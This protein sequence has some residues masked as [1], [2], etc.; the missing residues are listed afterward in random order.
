MVDAGDKNACATVEIHADRLVMAGGGT[1]ENRVLSSDN[2]P[3][4]AVRQ[5]GTSLPYTVVDTGQSLC[6]DTTQE[7]ACPRPGEQFY[8]QDA[9]YHGPQPAYRDNEDGT[10]SDLN[11]GLM[12][13]SSGAKKLTWQDAARGA[14]ACRVGGHDDW[15]L[16]TIKEMYSLILFSGTDP[17]LRGGIGGLK[18][19][20][21]T[22]F[23]PFQYGQAEDGDRL[24]DSQFATATRCVTPIMHGV[25]AMF[26][27]NFADGR[28]K[29]YPIEARG[30]RT[31][32]YHAFYVRGNPSYGRNDF[33]DNGD[34][35]VT[36]RATGL[37]WMKDDSGKGMT[38]EDALAYCENF[39]LAGFS[40]WRLPN[41]K[42]LQSI[43]DYT[44]SPDTS[45]SAALAPVFQATV[46]TNEGGNPDYPFYW[47]GTTHARLRGGMSAVYI[48]FGRALGFMEDRQRGGA[49]QLMD[50]HGAGAQRSDPK[51]GDP[52]RFPEGRG[53]QGDVVRVH[54][55]VRCVRTGSSIA[56]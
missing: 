47:T 42:E 52:R 8:G 15:R 40:D 1:V 4:A 23:F 6:Y 53:P 27:V 24:I 11:T 7:I 54:N 38:W 33:A 17:D 16:P 13:A 56:K 18:P 51:T 22:R 39:E 35:T 50:V 44:R 21:D 34:G 48:A 36:D 45:D 49:R 37:M 30:P 2:S 43:V 10:I 31:K 20:I 29:A 14:I 3:P 26:G 32:T 5:P 41:A 46:I 55:Y 28:I 19:F 12:W 25:Q 9:H